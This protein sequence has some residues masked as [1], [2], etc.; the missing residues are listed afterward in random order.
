M[1]LTCKYVLPYME[2]QGNGCI[3]NISSVN[4]IRT[5][6]DCI[7]IAYSTAKSGVIAFTRE[8]AVQFA[9]KGIRANA[10]LPG[11]MNTPLVSAS[12]A[13]AFGGSIGEAIK[14][15]D[16]MS[17]MKKQ[18]DAWDTAHAALFLASEEAKY[19]TGVALAIDGGLTCIT[20]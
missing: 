13:Q 10:I 14:R 2:K 3:I 5:F 12:L 18:G 7:S 11:L 20:R 1:F 17:P 16:A 8:I 6:P 15:R 19:I 9:S 4:A